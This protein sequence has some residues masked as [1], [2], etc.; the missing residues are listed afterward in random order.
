M[1]TDYA[2]FV[3]AETIVKRKS[4]VK[5]KVKALEGIYLII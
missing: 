2:L 4:S 5:P 3:P 1:Q